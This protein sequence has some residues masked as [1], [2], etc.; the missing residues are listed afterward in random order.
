MKPD[1]L[2]VVAAADRHRDR[3]RDAG[4]RIGIDRGGGRADDRRGFL[5][6]RGADFL[7]DAERRAMAR[8]NFLL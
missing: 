5:A 1:T 4:G 2:I 3:R 6:V 8:R 7:R